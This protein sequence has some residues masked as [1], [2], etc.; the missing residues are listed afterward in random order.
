MSEDRRLRDDDIVEI[1][2]IFLLRWEDA[3]QAHILL[4]P[5]GLVKLNETA[6]AILA[7]CTGAATVGAVIDGLLAGLALTDADTPPPAEIRRD[8][9]A[10]L[11]VAHAKDWIRIK[12]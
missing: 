5:E 7:A 1:N 12:P 11:E 4:Y 6:A 9:H 3:Q 10:F 8:I 2:P